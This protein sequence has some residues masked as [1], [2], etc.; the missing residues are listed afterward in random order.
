MYVV[1]SPEGKC[2]RGQRITFP[3]P[4]C[5]KGRTDNAKGHKGRSCCKGRAAEGRVVRRPMVFH[6][7]RALNVPGLLLSDGAPQWGGARLF[8]PSKGPPHE[9]GCNSKTK[10]KN[11]SEGAKSTVSPRATNPVHLTL[12]PRDVLIWK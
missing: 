3:L 10:S 4:E 8:A 2:A 12:I 1:C 9:S 6:P 11:R 7:A 5:P